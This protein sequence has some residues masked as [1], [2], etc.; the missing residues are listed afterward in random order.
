MEKIDDSKDP[1]D[2]LLW[3]EKKEAQIQSSTLQSIGRSKISVWGPS[4]G[5]LELEYDLCQ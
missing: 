3:V 5:Q 4:I 2:M 1:Q